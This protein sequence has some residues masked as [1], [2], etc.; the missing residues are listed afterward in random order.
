MTASPILVIQADELRALI[1]AEVRAALS[2]ASSPTSD[3]LTREQVAD[4][5][6]VDPVTVAT[7]AKKRGLPYSRLGRQWRFSRAA[8]TKWMQEQG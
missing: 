3:V 4:M 6:Q 2:D 5:L 1:R 8:V 7:Y